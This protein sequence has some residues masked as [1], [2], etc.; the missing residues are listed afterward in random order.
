MDKL[1]ALAKFLE[2]KKDDLQ[3][4]EYTHY[5][6]DVYSLGKKE[7]AIGT[8][9]EADEATKEEIKDSAWA[10]NTSFL[11]NYTDL[12]EEVFT[13][14]QDKCESSNDA[15]LR[16]IERSEDGFDGFVEKAIFADG[17]GRFLSGYDGEENEEGKYYIYRIN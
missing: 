14:M 15:V 17:R 1:T 5:G 3:K 10:F 16:L 13:C 7:Y 9:K 8:D 6:L 4:E 11:A 2:V 12:P